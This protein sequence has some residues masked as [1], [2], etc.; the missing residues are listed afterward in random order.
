M[1][2]R[3]P[4][5]TSCWMKTV[6]NSV[7]TIALVGHTSRQDACWQCLQTSDIISQAW[8]SP[9]VVVA[10]RWASLSMNLTCRQFWASSWPVLSKL[11][12][13]NAGALPESWFHSLQATSHALQPMQTLVSVKNPFASAIGLKP[14]QVGHDLAQAALLGIKVERQRG[15]LVHDRHRP[16]VPA[17]VDGEE[18]AVAGLAAVDPDV[19]EVLRLRVDRQPRARGLA[20]ARAD[21]P[22]VNPGGAAAGAEQPTRSGHQRLGGLAEEADLGEPAAGG[23]AGAPTPTLSVRAGRGGRAQ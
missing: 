17:G 23:A 3:Q 19:R 21:H 12:A 9:I 6:S 7:R 20:A 5:H 18:V 2:F 4:L 10:V 11:S 22:L 8:P 15:Q 14:H 13:R 16:R 1:Q